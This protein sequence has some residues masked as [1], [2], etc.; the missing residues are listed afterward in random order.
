MYSVVLMM[1]A[2]RWRV[3][4]PQ[5]HNNGGC[6]WEFELLAATAVTAAPVVTA[7]PAVIGCHGGG[8]FRG[9]GGH[10]CNG[11]CSG[12]AAR[13][14]RL[15][16]RPHRLRLQWRRPAGRSSPSSAVAAMCGRSR[17]RRWLLR[18]RLFC[19]VSGLL[20]RLHQSPPW[21]LAAAVHGSSRM[22]IAGN[23]GC[24]VPA[25]PM[26]EAYYP[27]CPGTI[28]GSRSRTDADR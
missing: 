26:P 10:G 5:S 23:S 22:L 4:V 1:G 24:T 14:V 6:C 28:K 18:D 11:G 16:W 2:H 9:H 3:E 21:L 13:F 15:Q 12:Y 20:L 8:L 27:C 7:A 19:C 17:L 25:S